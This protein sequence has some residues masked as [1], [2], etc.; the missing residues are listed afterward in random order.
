MIRPFVVLAVSWFV[1]L[2]GWS[3]IIGSLQNIKSKQSLFLPIVLWSVIMILVAYLGIKVFNNPYALLVG[4]ILS[5]LPVL[6][7]GKIE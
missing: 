3:Q 6:K 1:G 7:S 5:L 2:L 4:Y